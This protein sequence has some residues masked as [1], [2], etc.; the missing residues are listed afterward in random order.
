[1]QQIDEG[2]TRSTTSVI[3][4][5]ATSRG[6]FEAIFSRARRSPAA[7]SSPC[8]RSEMS[9]MLPRTSAPDELGRR[10]SLTSHGI[11]F[12]SASTCIHS[13]TGVA[14]PIACSM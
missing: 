2:S 3:D 12:P 9:M 4:A 13:N 6:S 8:L 14:P 10:T 5:S 1:M 11:S 7:M